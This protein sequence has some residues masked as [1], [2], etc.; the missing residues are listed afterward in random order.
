MLAVSILCLTLNLIAASA[1]TMS[2]GN[3]KITSSVQASGG[4]TSSGSGNKVI[5]GTA[6]QAAAGGS[7]ANSRY[8]HD[9]G[10][11][12]TTLASSNA[13]PTPTPTPTPSST[14]SISIND[15][16]QSEG[17]NG[18]TGF[19]F[20]VSLSAASAQMVTVNY[21]TAN[22]TAQSG[23]DFQSANGMLSFAPGETLKQIS[24]SVNGD[25][26]DE[27]TETFFVT[28][29][30]AANATINKASGT[31]TIV[32]D[33]STAGPEFNFSQA[34]Y[35]VQED[36]GALT[37]T[38]TRTGNS[39]A[40]ASVDYLTVDGSAV[41][42]SDFELAIGTVNFAPGETTRTITILLNE[43][44]HVEG[45]EGFKVTLIN[46]NGAA[47]GQTSTATVNIVDDGLE[48]FVNPIDDAGVFVYT[49]YHDF[50]NREPDS[51]GLQFWTN[52]I[53]SCGAD[54]QCREVKRI[55]VSA[56]FFLSIEFQE[57][58]YL[59]YLLEK[60]SFASTPKY[61]EFMR[62][63]QEV[64][65][66]VIVNSPGWQQK[67]KDNQE[68]FAEKWINRQAFKALYDSMSNADFVNAIY[69]NAGILPSPAKRDSLVNA[70]DVNS[71]S[72]AAVLLEVAADTGFRQKEN[73]AA[74][75]M[76]QYF[77]YLR[78]DPQAKPDSDLSGYNFWLNKLN[79]FNGDFQKAEMVKAFL[80]SIEYRGRF[81]Q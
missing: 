44:S 69:A 24:V 40:A 66:G 47:L 26:Q 74:F 25:T 4:G 28:L 68:Q 46:P 27:P 6:G 31:G 17:N 2:G 11:W 13:T 9:A 53:E 72:R 58:G 3:Y 67:I 63:I 65:R 18:I 48:S 43:D 71:Q 7:L 38:I 55:N 52:Q 45:T 19:T 34:N 32:N 15:V 14:P 16:S 39:N 30:N 59:R 8:S 37:V 21:A 60:E 49:H 79:S 64:S 62:D 61:T 33:D 80:D 35:S 23:S 42:K 75:V 10:F 54:A 81:A 56:S 36:L 12:P 70:L 51:A 5:E 77:G 76:M 20:T 57:T 78:R 73:S 29:S 22:N 41:Q 1:Q 50:L